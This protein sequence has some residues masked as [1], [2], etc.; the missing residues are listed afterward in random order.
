MLLLG[1]MVLIS[2]GSQCNSLFMAEVDTTE[3]HGSITMDTESGVFT[4]N[5]SGACNEAYITIHQYPVS[6]G[7][8]QDPCHPENIGQSLY[9]I[10]LNDHLQSWFSNNTWLVGCSLVVNSCGH[11]ACANIFHTSGLFNTW[12]ATMRS[13]LVGH[14]YIMQVRDVNP[15]TVIAEL[16]LLEGSPTS[17]ATVYFSNS[18]QIQASKPSVIADVGGRLKTARSRKELA[19]ISVMQYVVLE[20]E[21]Q[22]I[23]AEVK[24]MKSKEATANFSMNGVKGSFIIKQESPFHPTQLRLNLQNL[25]WTASHFSIHSLPVP[26]RQRST[27]DLCSDLGTGGLWNPLGVNTSVLS[28]STSPGKSHNLWEIGNL[29]GR[30]GTLQ[31]FK[32]IKHVLIDY[33]LP[34]YG[35]NSIIG[36]SV[37]LSTPDGLHRVCSTIQQEEE[38]T[39]AFASFH[40]EIIGRV[41]FRQPVDDPDDDLSILIEFASASGSTSTGHKWH[42]HEFPLL[43]EAENCA[44]AGRHF[45]PYN[46]ST[47][48]NY[49][50]ECRSHRPLLCEAGDYAGRHTTLTI[51]ADSPTRYFFTDTSSSLSG[52][53][54]II[55]KSLVVHGRDG[56]SSRMACANILLQRPLKAKTSSWF[57]TGNALGD[58][59]ISQTS[60][61][62]STSVH[63]HFSGL[64]SHAGGF[65]IH[66]LPVIERSSNPCSDDLIKGHFNPFGVD[67][68]ASPAEG[69][70]TD[71]E[72]ELGDISGRRGSLANKDSMDQSY[73][74]TNLPLF[75]TH[76]IL[77]RSLVIHYSNSSRMQ[78]ATLLPTMEPD[79]EQ[80]QATV[81]FKGNFTGSITMTQLVYPDGSFSDTMVLVDLEDGMSGKN[82]NLQ[83][84]IAREDD[85]ME[86]YNPYNL[87]DQIGSIPSCDPQNTLRC[88]VGDLT[89]KHGTII[90]GNRKIVTD[91]N[92][93]LLGDFTVIGRSMAVKTDSQDLFTTNILP[94]VPV[95]FLLV[96]RET[97]F[98]KL[99]LR[100]AVS[101][102]LHT[103]TWKVTLL[104]DIRDSNETCRRVNFFVIGFNDS[105]AL[106]L[107]QTQ[108]LPGSLRS[109]CRPALVPL[110]AYG[111]AN[112]SNLPLLWAI[113]C[114]AIVLAL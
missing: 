112:V 10:S 56:V 38:T 57:G 92:L 103:P 88:K 35:T 32:E 96:P 91:S 29:S 94:D 23:C 75:G 4:A 18:C 84:Y 109:T 46:I 67:V 110:E 11:Q 14:V 82:V 114:L 61:L 3:V 25:R 37:V 48:E 72:Y 63:I 85:E 53:A 105:K 101:V 45:N 97:P 71:D 60:D 22:R 68:S 24:Q 49:S 28:H 99:A 51:L 79:G 107:L 16:A 108:G 41:L 78:C 44:S 83:W 111:T 65:H 102:A 26:A 74:D 69:N 19:I 40:T 86:V 27:Q 15:V 12:R 58:L 80:I 66:Q 87:P 90:P 50:M 30:H 77:W 89:A 62:D 8:F 106:S 81:V 9:N 52:P 5:I 95:S 21:E 98:N 20:Y 104:P 1:M 42:V 59:T 64:N 54:S 70:G 43:T 13:F 36:R 33:N 73:K 100:D 2:W 17:S 93:P 34:L 39:I 55:G 113:M 47:G 76:S 31:G 6:Y 7:A